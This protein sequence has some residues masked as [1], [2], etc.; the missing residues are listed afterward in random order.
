MRCDLG[1]PSWAEALLAAG[2][3]P[4]Q[5]TVWVA[6]GEAGSIGNARAALGME[7][8]PVCALGASVEP[9]TACCARD[10]CHCR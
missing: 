10:A 8:L 5:P 1:E 3:D 9:S 2:F 7:G 4:S 6:E